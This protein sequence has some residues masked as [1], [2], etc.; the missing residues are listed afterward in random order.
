MSTLFFVTRW[1]SLAVVSR[2]W[3]QD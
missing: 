1:P 3:S 2:T